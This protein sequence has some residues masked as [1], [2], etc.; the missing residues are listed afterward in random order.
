MQPSKIQPAV[1]GGVVLGLLSAIPFVNLGNCL[2]CLWV[3]GGGALAANFYIKKAPEPV[4]VGEGALVGLLAGLIGTVI[5]LFVGLPLALLTGPLMQNM[6]VKLYEQASP[7]LARA[8]E[9]ELA[10]Q[11]GLSMGEKFLQMLPFQLLSLVITVA[12]ATVGGVIGVS[13]FEK[14]KGQMGLPPVHRP[15]SAT[16]RANYTNF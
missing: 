3:V 11:A 7:E 16:C 15:I 14:R 13:L 10:K 12:M 1:I 6:I 2:C 5:V 4:S 8:M 9:T